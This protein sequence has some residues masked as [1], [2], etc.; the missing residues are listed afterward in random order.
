MLF[1]VLIPLVGGLMALVVGGELLI[2][3]AS[4]LAAIVGVSSLVI[5]LTVVAFGTSAPE[6]VVSLKASFMGNANIAIANV[7]GSNI[8]NVFFILG[9][10]ALFMPLVVSSQLIKLDVP[11]ML[12]ASGLFYAFVF[13]GR[14]A[15]L[16]GMVLFTILILYTVF[17]V[18][19]SR[20]ESREV[21]QEFDKE[22]GPPEKAGLPVVVVNFFLLVAGLG[23]LV[24]GGEYFV[25]GAVELASNLGV[26]DTLIG[27]TI[28][29]AGTSLPEVVTSLMATLKGERDIAIGNVIGSNIYNIL[30]ITG[31][32]AMIV[33]G[34]LEVASQMLKFDIP[35]ML[36]ASLACLPIFF[37]ELRVSRIESL[38]LL[39]GYGLYIWSLISRA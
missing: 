17:L 24:L 34:G 12:G 30:A 16:E 19:K 2:R 21:K 39:G 29:S 22:F 23:F 7:V 18:R 26:S 6:L 1:N 36:V 32:S 4:R 3:G 33:P 25:K 28:V 10:C 38:V 8:F 11:I 27:L 15:F 31:L 37:T 35:I 9:G 14:L 5:G 13:N 20:R